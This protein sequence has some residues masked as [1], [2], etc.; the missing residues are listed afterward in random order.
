M[1]LHCKVHLD[2]PKNIYEPGDKLT[3]HVELVLEVRLLIKA[4]AIK[5]T[6]YAE[7]QWE[8]LLPVKNIKKS[9]KSKKQADRPEQV[10]QA[11]APPETRIEVYN[12]REEF[13]SN[14]NYFVGS[15]EASARIMERATYT[16]PFTVSLPQSCPS[17]F[18]SVNGHIRYM[19]EVFVEHKN[20]KEVWYSQQLHVLKPLDL[21]RC[22]QVACQ[23]CEVH[24]QENLG[25]RLF[26]EPL[27][28]S[29]SLE[30]VGF[31]PGEAISIHVQIQNPDKL[32]LHEVTYELQQISCITASHGHK[33]SKTRYFHNTLAKA[34]HNL[35]GIRYVGVQ[36]LQV[37]YMPQGVVPNTDMLDCRCLQ[38]GYELNVKLSTGNKKRS[39][40]ATIPITVGTVA[41]HTAEPMATVP[42]METDFSMEKSPKFN[43]ELATDRGRS[44][45]AGATAPEP[46][47]TAETTVQ[48]RP[49][50]SLAASS[51]REAEHLPK[52]KFVAERKKSKHEKEQTDYKPIYLYYDKE[53]T[54]T[55]HCTSVSDTRST[56]VATDQMENEGQTNNPYAGVMQQLAREMRI[57][58]TVIDQSL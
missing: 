48:S 24:V 44:N 42:Q 27:K 56:V 43:E 45:Y 37:L 13:L 29:V 17:S 57:R 9:L 52:T 50:I 58:K 26:K 6:G 4:V 47:T 51:F 1:V 2:N 10:G 15:D 41:L 14:I 8:T 7:V 21:R 54:A 30:Q 49:P 20:K 22:A 16:Y 53:Q 33:K 55:V 11:E 5:Y 19:I 18:E 46:E 36:H 28:M 25:L 32:Q 3:G 39:L 34:V 12:N 38:V 31:V 23:P 40:A 35:S